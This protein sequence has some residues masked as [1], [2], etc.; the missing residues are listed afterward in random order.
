MMKEMSLASQNPRAA[1]VRSAPDASPFESAGEEF[2]EREARRT[3]WGR[4][5]ITLP[6]FLLCGAA[7]PFV[8]TLLILPAFAADLLRRPRLFVTSR[9][10]TGVCL[11]FACEALGLVASGGVWL[12]GLAASDERYLR[13]NYALQRVWARTLMLGIR[14]LLGL[15]FQVEE[16]KIG[17]GPHIV[18]MRHASIIDTL[19][20]ITLIESFRPLQFRYVMKQ[21]LLWE[22][23]LDVV[24]NR[25]PNA[26]VRRGSDQPQREVARL[27]ALARGLAAGGA[28]VIYPEGTRFTAAKRERL[29]ARLAQAGNQEGLERTHAFRHVFPPKTAGPL[30]L[31]ASVPTADVVFVAH[32]GLE[33]AATFADLWHGR[34]LGNTVRVTLWKVP[35]AEIPTTEAER[36]AWLMEQWSKLDQWVG[37]ARATHEVQLLTAHT[38]QTLRR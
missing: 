17:P 26:F 6:L 2:T 38:G 14:K 29:L 35:A 4:R 30:A 15:R 37:Q 24:G 23:C 8:W 21:E 5:A 10:L 20:P 1:K 11:Y 16:A 34:L 36:K 19:L 7:S 9:A 33:D 12:A 32:S 25:L 13:W 28:V 3:R 18:F 22:P 31:L 27:R